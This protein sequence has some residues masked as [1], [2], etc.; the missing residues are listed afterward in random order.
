MSCHTWFYRKVEVS[1]EEA[2]KSLIKKL[3]KNIK[4]CQEWIDNPNGKDYLEIKEFY[5]EWTI[6]YLYNQVEVDKRKISIIKKDLCKVAVMFKYEHKGQLTCFIEGRGVYVCYDNLPHDLFRL[7]GYP[8]DNLFSYEQT[9]DFIEN[10][11]DQI[12]YYHDNKV[13]GEDCFDALKRFWTDYPE[14]MIQ[15]G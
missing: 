14:G 3:N 11:K 15:F 13:T 2:K 4:V 1:Y 10:H 8:D 12:Y 6:G 7:G 9:V 5:P